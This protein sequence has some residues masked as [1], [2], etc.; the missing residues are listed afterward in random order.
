[1]REHGFSRHWKGFIMMGGS[2]G[3]RWPETQVC[4]VAARSLDSPHV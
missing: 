3:E 2:A 1:M 4:R